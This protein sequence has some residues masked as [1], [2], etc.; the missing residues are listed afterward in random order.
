M[1]QAKRNRQEKVADLNFIIPLFLKGM[2]YVA[3]SKEL[4]TQR[5]YKLDPDTILKDVQAEL[6]RWRDERMG[7][8]DLQIEADLKKID[9][10]EQT[11]WDSWER[12]KNSKTKTVQKQKDIF[13][14]AKKP[15]KGEKLKMELVGRES[16][17]HVTESVGDKQ[18]L[19]GVQWCIV[20]RAELLQYKK[21]SPPGMDDVIPVVQAVFVTRSR[22]NNDQF[23]EAIEIP[24]E[25]GDNLQKLIES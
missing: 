13:D 15:K 6:K 25:T 10:L 3:I 24:E 1:G 17:K 5:T 21:V 9:M 8:I 12:S 20:Q 22:K 14:K 18:W 19:D 4:A 23:T 2:G 11:Y 7:M 16:Q